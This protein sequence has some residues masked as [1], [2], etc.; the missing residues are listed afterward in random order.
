VRNFGIR[1]FTLT[2]CT[3]ALLTAPLIPPPKAGANRSVGVEKTKAKNQAAG[4]GD[5]QSPGSTDLR[6]P[7][8]PFPPP[9]ND[10]FDRK[11]GGGAGM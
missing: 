10:D 8:A 2:L 9:M 7:T 3:T 6:S 4:S 1:L 11:A 5:V